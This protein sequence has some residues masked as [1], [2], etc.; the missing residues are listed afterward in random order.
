MSRAAGW[1]GGRRRLGPTEQEYK[2]AHPNV[3]WD[4]HEVHFRMEL[5]SSFRGGP[6]VTW[7]SGHA[8]RFDYNGLYRDLDASDEVPSG[9]NWRRDNSWDGKV[10]PHWQDIRFRDKDPKVDDDE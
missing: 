3:N 7:I 10:Q 6:R 5:G 1:K 4:T 9:T 8:R 2:R